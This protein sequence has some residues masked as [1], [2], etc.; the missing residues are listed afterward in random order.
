MSKSRRR[1]GVTAG[2]R[3]RLE[4]DRWEPGRG[5]KDVRREGDVWREAVTK[6][7]GS[8]PKHEEGRGEK[9]SRLAG[10]KSERNCADE[11]ADEGS[12]NRGFKKVYGLGRGNVEY[13][14]CFGARRRE[15]LRREP[16]FEGKGLTTGAEGE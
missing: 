5:R 2:G 8:G 12:S 4:L 13:K 3:R 15:L 10:R 6:A 7:S 1:E 11:G 14:G 16:G 9:S